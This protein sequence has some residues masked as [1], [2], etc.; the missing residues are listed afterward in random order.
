MTTTDTT[1]A[2][3]EARCPICSDLDGRCMCMAVDHSPSG[4]AL[5]AS[6][7]FT[8]P[9]PAELRQ[10]RARIGCSADGLARAL[11]VSAGTY[12][13]WEAGRTGPPGFLQPALWAIQA[14]AAG[15]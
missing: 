9:S 8:S 13:D 15:R 4:P 3:G 14:I 12:A 1:C 5:P 2:N 6:P 11:G 7:A 10:F